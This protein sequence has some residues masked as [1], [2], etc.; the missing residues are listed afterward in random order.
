MT[1]LYV[2]HMAYE[3]L[4]NAEKSHRDE[5]CNLRAISDWTGFTPA[6]SNRKAEALEWLVKQRQDIFR[7]AEGSV[8]GVEPGWERENRRKRYA[9]ITRDALFGATA[10]RE[11]RLPAAGCTPTET[12]SHPRARGLPRLRL[13]D[14]RPA[15]AQD[16]ERQLA[17]D[18]TK[19]AL[20]PRRGERL[21]R[22][23]TAVPAMTPW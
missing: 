10:Q 21:E 20:R 19:A 5:Y 17:R 22:R 13:G 1:S 7:R 15:Q 14:R 2:F 3:H 16:R 9:A 23:A 4:T 11:V 12:S 8:D 6:Q 18:A